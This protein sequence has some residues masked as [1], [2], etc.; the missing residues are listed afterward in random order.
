MFARVSSFTAVRWLFLLAGLTAAAGAAPLGGDAVRKNLE[1]FDTIWVTVRDTYWDPAALDPAKGGIDWDGAR[2]EFRPKVESAGSM[3]EARSVMRAMLERLGQSHFAVIPGDLYG[4]VAAGD[5]PD[6]VAAG[7]YEPGFDFA[8]VEGKVLATA[9]RSGPVRPG[10]EILAAGGKELSPLLAHVAAAF[11]TSTMRELMQARAV[12][13]RLTGPPGS[14]LSVRCRNGSDE[15][16]EV[17]VPLVAP[18]GNRARFGLL[19]A[20]WVRIESSR[21]RPDVGYISFNMF[22]DPARLMPAMEEALKSFAGTTGVI[23]DLRGNPGGLGVMAMGMAGWFVEKPDQRLGSM[24][25]RETTLQF[26]VNPRLPHYGGRVAILIDGGSASTSEI[27]ASGMQDLRRARVFGS[28]SAGAALPSVIDRLPNGDAF[29]HAAANY[30]SV[31]GRTLEGLGVQPDEP[32][33]LTRTALLDGRDT[34]VEAAVRWIRAGA[35]QARIP[36]KTMK[37]GQ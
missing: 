27:F 22:L 35:P 29:Q 5:L 10:W 28:R 3:E 16:I 25:M 6:G 24:Q 36:L 32:V 37:V 19:P 1:A 2:R 31:N 7:E 21:L 14:T 4:D 26:V 11:E 20:Q 8:L 9:V 12:R 34:V 18:R 13:T 17:E 15:L 23:L 30:Q 33:R